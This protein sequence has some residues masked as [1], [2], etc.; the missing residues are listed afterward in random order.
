MARHSSGH[1]TP[2]LALSGSGRRGTCAGTGGAEVCNDRKRSAQQGSA[3]YRH[4]GRYG[5]VAG[6]DRRWLHEGPNICTARTVQGSKPFSDWLDWTI[7]PCA[8][9]TSVS[10]SPLGS[11]RSDVS[12]SPV[13]W[14]IFDIRGCGCRHGA[15][16]RCD[17]YNRQRR[18]FAC[19]RSR[20]RRS[21]RGGHRGCLLLLAQSGI[22]A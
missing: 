12:V 13:W 4:R 5:P 17:D 19:D 18:D 6:G 8:A 21:H 20:G 7:D 2:N 3:P 11:M 15:T 14:W 22:T 16:R 10:R 9:T 1:D